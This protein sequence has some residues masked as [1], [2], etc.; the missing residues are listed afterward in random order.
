MELEVINTH[1]DILS[2]CIV[3]GDDRIN[4]ERV[5][6]K[7]DTQQVLIKVYPDCRVQAFAPKNATNDEVLAA[8]QKRGRW[9]Y[10]KL[11]VFREQQ[12]DITPRKYISGESHYYLGKQHVLKVIEASNGPQKVRLLRGKLKLLFVI[13]AQRKLIS[14]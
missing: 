9:I 2:L 10:K 1:V 14:Y 8:V 12:A 6:R 13:T 7:S 4:F 3:Y 5:Q 11:C